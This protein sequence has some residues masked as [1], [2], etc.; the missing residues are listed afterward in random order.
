VSKSNQPSGGAI[1]TSQQIDSGTI[2]DP[3]PPRPVIFPVIFNERELRA[4][5]DRCQHPPR[6]FQFGV[7]IACGAEAEVA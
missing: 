1:R 4:S 5:V 7:E 6:R 2:Q 3:L